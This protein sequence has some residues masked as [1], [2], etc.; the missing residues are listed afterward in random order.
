MTTMTEPHVWEID[1]PI[2]MDLLS[3]NDRRNHWRH[4]EAVREW[5]GAAYAA[6]VKAKLP[7]GLPRVRIDIV[8]W[9]AH[10]KDKSNFEP[11]CKV[12]VDGFGPPYVRK[13]NPRTGF[14]GAA[15]PGYGLIPNDGPTHLD[16]HHLHVLDPLPPRGRVLAVITDLTDVPAGRTWTPPLPTSTGK[17]VRS[18]RACNGC[19]RLLGDVLDIE[20]DAVMGSEPLPDVRGECPTCNQTTEGVTS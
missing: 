19:S 1:L 4:A 13:P 3:A 7:K 16:G 5:R 8:I 6:A 18:K 11:V 15:A 12:I 17:R 14:K 20:I 10:K 9:P 2:P